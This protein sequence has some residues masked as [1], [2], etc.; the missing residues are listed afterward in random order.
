LIG[1]PDGQVPRADFGT[2][3]LRGAVVAGAALAVGV[4]VSV[5]V[6]EGVATGVAVAEGLTLAV[7]VAVCVIV[8]IDWDGEGGTVV[9]DRRSSTVGTMA[10]T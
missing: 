1:N 6:A 8:G 3:A 10:A 4:G 7:A 9:G 2:P 5:A